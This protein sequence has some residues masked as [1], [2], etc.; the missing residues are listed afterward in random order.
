MRG[1]PQKAKLN[2][3]PKEE[4]IEENPIPDK[5]KVAINEFDWGTISRLIFSNFYY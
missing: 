1:G 5:K 3:K 4:L 2:I